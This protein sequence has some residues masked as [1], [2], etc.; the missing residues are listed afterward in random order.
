MHA[1]AMQST[2][3]ERRTDQRGRTF[4]SGKIAFNRHFSVFDCLV[5]NLTAHGACLEVANSLGV[6]TRFELML[7]DGTKYSCHMIWR[8]GDRIG[9]AFS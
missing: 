2:S 6:P 9:V 1:A 5:R 8:F 7:T 4:K 3:P